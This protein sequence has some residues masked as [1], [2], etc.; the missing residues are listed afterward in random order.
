MD[1]P[2]IYFVVRY[3]ETIQPRFR[4][5]YV[6]GSLHVG[7][8]DKQ[9]FD[10]TGETFAWDMSNYEGGNFSVCLG[11]GT[12]IGV[13]TTVRKLA[14][15]AITAFW[16]TSFSMGAD[17]ARSGRKYRSQTVRLNELVRTSPVREE[18]NEQFYEFRAAPLQLTGKVIK[19]LASKG[20]DESD[21]DPKG[22]KPRRTR[23][24]PRR[25]T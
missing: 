10:L 5:A 18:P 7:F 20:G 12:P 9:L 19:N 11:D 14:E 17:E 25:K 4:K 1:F 23:K 8:S 15:D 22:K 21:G 16:K 13:Y 2:Y 6:F 24:S 3:V